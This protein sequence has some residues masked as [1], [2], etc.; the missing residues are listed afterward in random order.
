[1]TDI[2]EYQINDGDIQYEMTDEGNGRQ[3]RITYNGND[4]QRE[5][6]DNWKLFKLTTSMPC[7]W[8]FC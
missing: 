6:K 7:G 3:Y 8:G 2:G 4:R 5:M 1:M